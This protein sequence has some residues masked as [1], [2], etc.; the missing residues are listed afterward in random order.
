MNTSQL[1]SD[2]IKAGVR[3]FLTP[4]G[5]IKIKGKTA[6]IHKIAP[7]LALHKQEIANYLAFRNCSRCQSLHQ[8]PWFISYCIRRTDL[9]PAYGESHPLRKLPDD[10]GANCPEFMLGWEQSTNK[11][12][13]RT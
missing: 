8:T 2:A 3:F 12:F 13:V 9:K 4:A 10:H 1:I 5:T 6:L 7:E 11:I